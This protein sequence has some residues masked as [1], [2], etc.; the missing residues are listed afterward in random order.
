MNNQVV[1][2]FTPVL[3]AP[4]ECTVVLPPAPP[5]ADVLLTLRTATFVPDAGRYIRQQGKAV[6]GQ[7]QRLG[8]RLDWVRLERVERAAIPARPD[9]RLHAVA[10][11]VGP[12]LHPRRCA[13]RRCGAGTPATR[14]AATSRSTSTRRR[15]HG[16]VIVMSS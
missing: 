4:A 13:W 1:G 7:V 16:K 2:T 10:F 15:R 3:D 9:H 8:L 14:S 6:V 5:G 12:D 11:F